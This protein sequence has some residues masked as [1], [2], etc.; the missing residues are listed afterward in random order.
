MALNRRRLV[1][2]W[3]S[4]FRWHVVAE[5]LFGACA[6]VLLVRGQQI[7]LGI[8]AGCLFAT[9][10]VS[11][12][13]VPAA[14]LPRGGLLGDRADVPVSRRWGRRLIALRV[15]SELVRSG[16]ILLTL[17]FMVMMIGSVV[18]AAAEDVADL[19]GLVVA[20]PGLVAIPWLWLAADR[21]R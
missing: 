13:S 11:L 6:V 2:L 18:D 12:A 14:K 1:A 5:L 17:F 15:A 4:W 19:W 10:A 20:I 3:R 8:A 21:R 9:F 16:L 7:G